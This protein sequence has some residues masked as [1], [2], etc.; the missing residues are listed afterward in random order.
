MCRLI[1]TFVV[2]IWYKQVFSW[3]VPTDRQ[4]WENRIGTDQCSIR[5]VIPSASFIHY[6]MAKPHYSNF[7][8]SLQLSRLMTK[9]TKWSVR[10]AKTKISLGIWSESLQCTQW[11]AEDPMFL[12]ADSEDSDQT[13]QMPRLIWVFAGRTCHFVGFVMRWLNSF[14]VHCQYALFFNVHC[15]CT[16]IRAT[17]ILKSKSV[18]QTCV[19]ESQIVTK[20][21]D[22]SFSSNTVSEID[23]FSN[24]V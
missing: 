20:T 12:H 15:T 13:G 7:R 23:Y 1:C 8:I 14:F 21:N 4:I 3:C 6:Y 24:T 22:S 5:F 16:I 2:R 18:I 9:P 10:P 17:E 11:V 19:R